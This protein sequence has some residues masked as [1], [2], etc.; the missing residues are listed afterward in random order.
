MDTPTNHQE[1]PRVHNEGG[2]RKFTYV[3]N[4]MNDYVKHLEM[5]VMYGM[6]HICSELY[7]VWHTCV[8]LSPMCLALN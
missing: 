6:W 5:M 8:E 1:T 4:F 2:C 3:T 7:W